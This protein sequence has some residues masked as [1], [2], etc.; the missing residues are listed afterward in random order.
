M[1]PRGNIDTPAQ[2]K[3]VREYLGLDKTQMAKVLRFSPTSGRDSVRRIE[4]GEQAVPGPI[5]RVLEAFRDGWRPYGWTF[6][7]DETEK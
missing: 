3:A 7:V 2:A 1:K 4:A 5:Q 6:P